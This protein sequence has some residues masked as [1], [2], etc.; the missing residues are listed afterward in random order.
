[1]TKFVAGI[2]FIILLLACSFF[3]TTWICM[4]VGGSVGHIFSI[5]YLRQLGFWKYAPLWI[6]IVLV[7]IVL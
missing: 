3:A 2:V 1:M 5:A 7:K 4:I 6:L